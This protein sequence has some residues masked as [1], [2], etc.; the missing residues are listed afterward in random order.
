MCVCLS[1]FMHACGDQS[2][3]SDILSQQAPPYVLRQS[4]IE[5]D[6]ARLPNS[7]EA[8][9]PIF[10]VL[11]PFL[12]LYVDARHSNSGPPAGIAGTVPARLFPQL[13]AQ[14]FKKAFTGQ[15]K[16]KNTARMIVYGSKSQHSGD[17]GTR[18]CCESEASLFYVVWGQPGLHR[19]TLPQTK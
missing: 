1:V 6:S 12:G 18:G 13:P 10:L 17:R 16:R 8:P 2:L 11:L 3:M 5:P 9:V 7:R 15:K 19:K 4:P 14:S